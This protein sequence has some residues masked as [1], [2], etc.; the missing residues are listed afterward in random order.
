MEQ[1]GVKALTNDGRAR[2]PI[3][4]AVGH[5]GDRREQAGRGDGEGRGP[6]S[7]H[8]VGGEERRLRVVAEGLYGTGELRRNQRFRDDRVL[9]GGMWNPRGR[10]NGDGSRGD[11]RPTRSAAG[12]RLPSAG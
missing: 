1:G 8:H 5:V 3:G 4:E 2:R 6:R 10:R 11:Q 7:G 9:G 12:A